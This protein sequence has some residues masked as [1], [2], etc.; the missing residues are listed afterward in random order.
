MTDD[1]KHAVRFSAKLHLEFL[2]KF[3]RDMQASNPRRTT[4]FNDLKTA[5]GRPVFSL[6]ET[7]EAQ[8]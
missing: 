7:A 5:D 1:D 2:K 8:L 3:T 4:Q 6:P